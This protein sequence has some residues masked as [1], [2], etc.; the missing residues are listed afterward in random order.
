MSANFERNLSAIEQFFLDAEAPQVFDT[1]LAGLL[2]DVIPNLEHF[3]ELGLPFLDRADRSAEV[4][5]ELA[6]LQA[7]LPHNTELRELLWDAY[8]ILYSSDG[9]IVHL[10]SIKHHRQLSFDV[11]PP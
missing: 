11:E 8:L 5:R 3:P 7:K 10:L 2:N 9:A 1:L 6:V 4:S